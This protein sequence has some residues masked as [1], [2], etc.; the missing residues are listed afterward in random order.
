[1]RERCSTGGEI[2]GST[3]ARL[4]KC[5]AIILDASCPRAELADCS[6]KGP[7]GE[8]AFALLK[9]GRRMDWLARSN[10]SKSGL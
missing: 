7:V 5:S 3:G 10:T 2:D 6:G 8:P 1:M 9:E 4:R